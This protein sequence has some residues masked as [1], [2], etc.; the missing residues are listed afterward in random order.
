MPQSVPDVRDYLTRAELAAEWAITVKTLANWASAGI[1]P[2]IT[3]LGSGRFAPVRYERHAAAE[4][5]RTK[6]CEAA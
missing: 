2:P 6:N 5:L 1:G 3:K 4:W